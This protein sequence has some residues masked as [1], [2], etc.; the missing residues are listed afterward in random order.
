MQKWFH[1]W[2]LL[3]GIVG[4][5]IAIKSCTDDLNSE[6]VLT[7]ERIQHIHIGTEQ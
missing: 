2:C 4:L 6:Y 5:S 1:V 3:M 7:G